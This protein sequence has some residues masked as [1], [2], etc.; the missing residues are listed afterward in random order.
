M[1]TNFLF[2][3]PALLALVFLVVAYAAQIFTDTRRFYSN[4]GKV[5]VSAN[6]YIEPQPLFP[7]TAKLVSFGAREFLA[8]WYW[9][10]LIQYYGGGDPQGKYRK[11][12]EMFNVVTE[13]SPK[14]SAAYQTGLLVL[15]GEGFIDEAIKLGEKGQKNLP[16]K[17]EMPYYTGIVYHVYKKDYVAAAKKFD[18]AAA[19]PGAPE[20]TKLFAAIYYNKADERQTAYQIFKTVYETSDSEFAR[21]RAEKYVEHLDVYFFLED[22]TKN[23][24]QRFGRYPATLDELVTRGVIKEI[25]SSPLSVPFTINPENGQISESK[26]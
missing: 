17:W 11:L 3:R 23:F 7:E 24:K 16:D 22:A 18:Q 21:D 10:K 25:P 2:R 6:I 9:L 13:L 26:R 4:Q 1:S 5:A 14:Y 20:T 15:P 19:I 8:D 12:G